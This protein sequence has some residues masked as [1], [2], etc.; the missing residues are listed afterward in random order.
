MWFKHYAY[1]ACLEIRKA[2][3]Q[4]VVGIIGHLEESLAFIAPSPEDG[5]IEGRLLTLINALSKH[6]ADT[7]EKDTDIAKKDVEIKHVRIVNVLFISS[8]CLKT[9]IWGTF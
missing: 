1:G 3:Y 7:K 6:D 5:P 4:E 8:F 9:L 2:E